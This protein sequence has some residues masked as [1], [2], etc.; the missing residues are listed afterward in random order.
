MDMQR[1][2]QHDAKRRAIMFESA[3]SDDALLTRFIKV[4][5]AILKESSAIRKETVKL[6]PLK[7]VDITTKKV[8]RTA[9]TAVKAVGSV[10]STTETVNVFAPKSASNAPLISKAID[11]IQQTLGPFTVSIASK[12]KDRLNI[13]KIL[14]KSNP[15][16]IE[17]VPTQL[18]LLVLKCKHSI[19]R[20]YCQALLRSSKSQ[21]RKIN[22][23]L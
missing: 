12:L 3:L 2:L 21:P 9:G 22:T 5:C 23:V 7:H 19:V 16:P 17:A 13:V 10:K 6:Q 15:S 8:E 18:N 4:S 1:L 11:L 14:K 20:S